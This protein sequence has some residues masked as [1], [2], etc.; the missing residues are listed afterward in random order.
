MFG[1]KS[2]LVLNR[3]LTMSTQEE[4][5]I[6]LM[7]ELKVGLIGSSFR[8]FD[9]FG[10]S[11]NN[12]AASAVHTHFNA[13]NSIRPRSTHGQDERY[14]RAGTPGTSL[15]GS[16]ALPRHLASSITGSWLD[17]AHA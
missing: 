1:P 12:A 3:D 7:L 13:A 2:Q 16:G 6:E 14:R 15:H 4:Q 10:A 9:G 17:L 11:E 5:L 8:V